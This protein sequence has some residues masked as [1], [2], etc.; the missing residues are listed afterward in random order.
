MAREIT[1][2]SR[3]LSLETLE[4]LAP[5][6]E[7]LDT[8]DPPLS[9]RP[10]LPPGTLLYEERFEI[11]EVLGSGGEG[12]VYRAF[13]QKRQRDVALKLLHKQ[14]SQS[15]A[16]LKREFRFL[17]HLAHPHLVHI[18][19]LFV[20]EDSAF[21]T[22]S[23][24]RGRSF[25][26]AARD[27]QLLRVLLAELASVLQFLHERGRLHRDIKPSN[28][29]VR[30][31][32]HLIL[33]DFG[34]ALDLAQDH[35]TTMDLIGTPRYLAPEIYLGDS[36]SAKSDAYA[37]GVLLYEALTG[38]FP[39][40]V[41][42]I[43]DKEP[44]PS[45][46]QY[47]PQL[48]EDLCDLALRL[49]RYHPAE[50]ASIQDILAICPSSRLTIPPPSETPQR[51][52]HFTGR[53]QELQLLTAL[54]RR[55]REDREPL[56]ALVQGASGMGKTAFLHEWIRQ[57][58][59]ALVLQGRCSEHELVPHQAFDGILESLIQDWLKQKEGDILELL[60]LEEA[61]PIIHL[62]PEFRRLPCFE[63]L[64]S[65]APPSSKLRDFRK[66]AYRG[67]ARMFE[68]LASTKQVIW[69]I[70]DVQWGDLDT[71][72]LLQEI[73]S[74]LQA[75]RCLLLLAFRT[76]E[77]KQSPCIHQLLTGPHSL[78]EYLKSVPL[79]LSPLSTQE[80]AQLLQ[81]R[82]LAAP[83]PPRLQQLLLHE[84]RG[85]P[86]LLTELV[87]DPSFLRE[88]AESE[89]TEPILSRLVQR[90][91]E[92]LSPAEHEAFSLLCCANT[93]IESDWLAKITGSDGDI[94]TQ[95]LETGRLIY[96]REGG[97]KMEIIHD[98]IREIHL[99]SL[100][101]QAAL[102]H[103]K[104]AQTLVEQGGEANHIAY[105]FAQSGD[106]VQASIWAE[107]AA[108]GASQTLALSHAAQLYRLAL[109]G[110]PPGSPRHT[111]LT[112]KL[113]NTLADAG[114]GQ[115]AAPV[116]AELAQ[117]QDPE[118]ATLF[119]QRAAAQ[120]LSS[121]RIEAGW[122]ELARVYQAAKLSWPESPQ[123]AV[124]RI[125][126]ERAKLPFLLK[127]ETP[128]ALSAPSPL[129]QRRLQ[130]CRAA[131]SVAYVSTVHGA[132]NNARYLSLAL[133]SGSQEDLGFAFGMEAAYRATAGSSEAE[134]VAEF[135]Q[136]AHALLSDSSQTYHSAFLH[137]IRGQSHYLMGEFHQSTSHYERAEKKLIRCR[138]V[139][140]ELSSSRIFWGS[141]LIFLGRHRELDRRLVPWITDARERDDF[142]ALVAFELHRLRRESLREGDHEY[143]LQEI[144]KTMRAW[145]APYL[146]VHRTLGSFV[147]GHTA[148]CGQRPDLAL[149]E[150][151]Q[152]RRSMK[153]SLISRAQIVRISCDQIE[154]I[155][156]IAEAAQ[157]L[158]SR[159]KEALQRAQRTAL[160]LRKERSAWGDLFAQQAEANLAWFQ[161]PDETALSQL[162]AARDAYA[163]QHFSLYAA[164]LDVRIGSLQGGEAGKQLVEQGLSAFRQAHANPQLGA[165][166]CFAPELPPSPDTQVQPR[167]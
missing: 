120:W 116:F 135:I 127:Q 146:G 98:A 67:L 77:A 78:L 90:R 46:A 12:T 5:A 35:D 95:K 145:R 38:R 140:W 33:L 117:S 151:D 164:A 99:Q 123:H 85:I 76:E 3:F 148:T 91:T 154:S 16:Q 10:L 42:A 105:H 107:R 55:T 17:R 66:K 56:L 63:Q 60:P 87:S 59:E 65:Q 115:E 167:F 15:I 45:P 104:L 113:A 128:S 110:E 51:D 137:Y 155:A 132:A 122:A 134:R 69:V 36:P 4:Q 125:T 22:M 64:E 49:L 52:Q 41:L 109:S 93:H 19:E 73:F 58:P 31:D 136:R 129:E 34:I 144:K 156:A 27:H 97:R 139:A 158:G 68:R 101:E 11:A 13:D 47:I 39:F 8:L 70:D 131:W 62:F 81:S 119:R 37:V 94:L 108:R 48:P 1:K 143:V 106:S 18:H 9:Q 161:R 86:L 112:E 114:Y 83:L 25:H 141:A 163:A 102:Y 26:E 153:L 30:D 29:L 159:R 142:Y 162:Q 54:Y 103:R 57:F 79:N 23:L 160:R 44:P 7:Y 149:Q 50:R 126:Y 124:L 152:L 138:D 74:S 2:K 150:I 100:G 75:P 166:H 133:Q 14:A 92:I 121:G 89:S 24:I 147:Y 165:L 32:N 20:D 21:F 82:T 88:A 118:R 40:P 6:T 61:L 28:L 84:A 111:E 72:K 53:G 43:P 71:C 80:A 96:A 130:A 157:H